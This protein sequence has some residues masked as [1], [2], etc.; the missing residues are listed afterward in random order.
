MHENNNLGPKIRNLRESKKISVEELANLSGTSVQLIEQLEEGALVPS[1]TPLLAIARALGVRLGTFLDDAPQSGPVLSKPDLSDD[2]SGRILR[3]SGKSSVKDRSTLDFYPLASDKQDRHME[4][5]LIEVHPIAGEY[6]L[7]SHEGE[8]FIYVLEGE[9]E[10]Y[11]GKEV[12]RVAE[13]ESIYYDSIVP[14]DLHTF[15]DK[16]SKILAVIYTPI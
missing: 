8:E 11:Y 15:G 9:I 16:T 5:F 10:L 6:K 4:P 14:H 3:F 2:E 1:L 7:S 13:G 12:Y